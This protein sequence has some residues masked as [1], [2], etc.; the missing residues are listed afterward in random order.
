MTLPRQKRP[1]HQQRGNHTGG[2]QGGHLQI[3]GLNPPGE[4]SREIEGKISGHNFL[5]LFRVQ[6]ILDDISGND[7]WTT[8]ILIK[9][10]N[11]H[12]AFWRLQ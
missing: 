9:Q 2:T 8:G 4:E 12:G 6:S 11:K 3:E 1:R 7:D 10:P 5:M